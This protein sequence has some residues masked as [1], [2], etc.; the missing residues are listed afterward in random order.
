MQEKWGQWPEGKRE[1]ARAGAELAGRDELPEY[2][3]EYLLGE[4]ILRYNAMA[5]REY[6]EAYRAQQ[7]KL[8]PFLERWIGWV[9]KERLAFGQK[10]RAARDGRSCSSL[11][12]QV[13][14]NT[15][16]FDNEYLPKSLENETEPCY[17][18]EANNVLQQGLFP[19]KG[20]LRVFKYTGKI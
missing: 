13:A 17:N 10:A 9:E 7:A 8:G 1:E 18:Y 6:Q 19:K 12:L 15:I 20:G 14:E 16:R 3:L 5:P 2:V 4:K 11:L